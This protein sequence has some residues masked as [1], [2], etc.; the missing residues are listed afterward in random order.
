MTGATTLTFLSPLGGLLVLAAVLPVAGLALAGRRVVAARVLLGLER[1]SGGAPRATIAALVAVPVLLGVAAAQPALRAPET[2]HVRTDAQAM[3]ILD[4]SRSMLAAASPGEQSRLA[5]A[6]RAAVRLRSALEDIPTGVGTLTDRALPN[7]L[8]VA[9]T[10]AFDATVERAIGI[11][12]PPPQEVNVNATILAPLSELA[13][14]GYYSPS[15]RRRLLVVLTDGES[16]S[17]ELDALART[18][19]AGRVSL[20][21]VHVRKAGERVY[22]SGG[23]PEAAYLSREE[24]RREL[25]RLAAAAG[26]A[27]FGEDELGAAEAR[28][29]SDLGSGTSA[30]QGIRPNTIPLAPY[31]AAASLLPLA[32]LLR[33]RRNTSRLKPDPRRSGR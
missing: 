5:R 13:T 20:I 4:T 29:R 10:A 18:L 21:L 12:R 6:K 26:G 11:E 14:Q 15:A 33:P 30:S 28:A 17:Y 31:V 24:T 25:D 3:F 7:L 23:R 2:A 32:Y 9:D 27:S 22:R 1:P 16:R 19:R 8:P